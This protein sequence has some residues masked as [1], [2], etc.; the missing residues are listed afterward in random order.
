MTEEPKPEYNPFELYSAASEVSKNLIAYFRL[1][2]WAMENNDLRGWWVR[3]DQAN[4]EADYSFSEKDRE[5]LLKLWKKINPNLKTSFGL[6]KEYHLKLR[7]LCTK[8]FTMISTTGDP[9]TAVYR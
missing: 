1:A 3:L 9:R 7:R 5:D 2:N 8:F 4:M 6:L